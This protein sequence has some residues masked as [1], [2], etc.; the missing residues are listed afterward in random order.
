MPAGLQLFDSSGNITLD[1]TTYTVGEG[2]YTSGT[3][4]SSGTVTV[5]T[6]TSNSVV[7]VD[8]GVSS[9]TNPV[10]SVSLNTSAK[11]VTV[12]G[13]GDPFSLSYRIVDLP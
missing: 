3:I 9:S 10:V 12:T 7:L 4:T 6:I 1:T 11:T 5:S 8:D 13:N 2:I